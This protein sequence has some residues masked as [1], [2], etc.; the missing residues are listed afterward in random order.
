MTSPTKTAEVPEFIMGP[1]VSI[2]LSFMRILWLFTVAE[3]VDDEEDEEEDKDAR[4][5]DC[6]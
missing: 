1:L 3:A 5:C 2:L 6:N 4:L